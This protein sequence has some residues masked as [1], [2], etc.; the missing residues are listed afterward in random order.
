MSNMNQTIIEAFDFRHATKKFN[1]NKKISEEDFDTIL[2]SGRLSPSSL[3]LEPWRFVVIQNKKLRDKLK[4]YSWGAQKQLD[5][6]SHF[7]LI[8]ARKNVTAHSNYVQHLIR[9]IKEYEESTIPAVEEKF[10]NFQ[11]SFH[12]ADNDRTLYDWAS[13]QTY[14][15]LGNMMTSAAL[16]GIDS[17]PMEGFD[18]DKVTEILSEEGILDTE[19]FGISVMVAFGYRA[20]E[21]AHG[22]IRQSKEDV[23]SWIE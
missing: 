14:I 5:T 6:A 21:P 18:L 16:L 13:K 8:F 12:I 2:E 19:H 17:C 22:K 9:G 20:Q 4:P 23:I 10:D 15:A 1:P 7:V 3:G 11:A